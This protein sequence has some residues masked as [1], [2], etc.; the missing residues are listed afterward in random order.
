MDD[1]SS[2]GKCQAGGDRKFVGKDGELVGPAIAIGV[3]ADPDPVTSLARF[4]KFVW[5]VD[6]LADP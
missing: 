3:L 2:I 6:G 1:Q 5:I 4:L